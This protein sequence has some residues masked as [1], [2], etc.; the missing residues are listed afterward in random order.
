MFSSSKSKSRLHPAFTYRTVCKLM[1]ATVGQQSFSCLFSV[2]EQ[3]A[4]FGKGLLD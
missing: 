4:Q 3:G 1:R 2:G